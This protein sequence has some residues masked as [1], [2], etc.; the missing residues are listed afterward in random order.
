MAS[1]TW[2]TWVWV[3]SGS[4]WWTRRPGVLRF[5]GSQRVGHDWATELNWWLRRLRVCLRCGR[6][7]FDP[8]VTRRSPGEGNGNPLQYSCLEN[9]MDTVHRVAKSRT[10]LSDFT[11]T[12]TVN[13]LQYGLKNPMYRGAWQA[14]AHGV[15]RVGHD[16]ATK[17]PP[18]P[19]RWPLKKWFLQEPS[20]PSHFQWRKSLP[21]LSVSNIG[22]IKA[23]TWQMYYESYKIN[24][25]IMSIM[26]PQQLLI[27]MYTL[28]LKLFPCNLRTIGC[29]SPEIYV[30]FYF[31]ISNLFF[32]I[33]IIFPRVDTSC[34]TPYHSLAFGHLSCRN[35]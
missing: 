18:P 6:L 3:N 11:F 10:R 20:F 19:S 1:P 17:P 32:N 4:W 26:M 25:T 34:F 27:F 9:P 13:P 7:G 35:F 23:T 2:W 8:G 15:A 31:Y 21:L 30:T 33:C 24:L 28:K 22:I 14:T 5:M 16:L 29:F 12:F